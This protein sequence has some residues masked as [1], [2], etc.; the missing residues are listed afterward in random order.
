MSRSKNLTKVSVRCIFPHCSEMAISRGLCKGHYNMAADL[1]RSGKT[2]WNRLVQ[3]KKA[4]LAVR[5]VEEKDWFLDGS[6]A[7][8]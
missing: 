4:K 6:K 2:T 5:R 8:A 3:V 1:V 7:K